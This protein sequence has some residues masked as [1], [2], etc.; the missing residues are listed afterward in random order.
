MIGLARG[1]FVMAASGK[2]FWW[3][4]G[5]PVAGPGR[6]V[7]LAGPRVSVCGSCAT[8]RIVRSG[9]RTVRTELVVMSG[10]T[11]ADKSSLARAESALYG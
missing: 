3:P 7:T 11:V 9:E 1:Q 5:V 4:P 6:R 8:V 2:G 10:S